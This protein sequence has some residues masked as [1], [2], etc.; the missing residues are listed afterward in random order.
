MARNT[1]KT[2]AFAPTPSASV[3]TAVAVN[4][5]DFLSCRS[6]ELHIRRDR[7]RPRPL[8]HFAPA[9][10]NH[11]HIPESPPR[12]ML[13]LFASHALANKLLCLLVDVLAHLFRQISVE[14]A[15]APESPGNDAGKPAHHMPQEI[16]LPGFNT[17]AMPANICSK[18]DLSRS[19]CFMPAAV[20][21]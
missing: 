9:L 3:N 15:A 17:S 21:W 1:L 13:S 5:R 18:L 2:A 14:I 20:I 8:P 16:A 11:G 10:F 12:R 6:S 4:P 7:L 19:R